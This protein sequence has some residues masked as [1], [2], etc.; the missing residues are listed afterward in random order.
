LTASGLGGLALKLGLQA[1]LH[2]LNGGVETAGLLGNGG[3]IHH[4]L[5]SY[6]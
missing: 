1:A 3:E 2:I 5:L 6:R 4:D